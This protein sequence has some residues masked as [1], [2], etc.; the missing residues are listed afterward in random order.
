MGQPRIFY[1]MAKDGLLFPIFGYVNPE[2]HVPTAGILITGVV[3]ATLACL[4]DLEALA[5]VISLGTLLVFTFVDAAVIILRLRP[6]LQPCSLSDRAFVF[7]TP[8]VSRL[9][10]ATP[11]QLTR[12]IRPL[13]PTSARENGS[14]P[15][16]LLI[17]FAISTLLLA[18]SVRDEWHV[19]LRCGFGIT[20]VI[21]SSI[22][23]ALPH[24]DPP[25][26]FNCPCVPLVPLLG[27]AANVFM[28]GSLPNSSW[29]LAMLWLLV[30]LT[31]YLVYGMR[32]STLGKEALDEE[33]Q[34][35]VVPSSAHYN[36][37]PSGATLWQPESFYAD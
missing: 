32:N 7:Q 24:S 3:V 36:A 16:I 29:L 19:G 34:P 12:R 5:N 11:R 28:A 4:V 13:W 26:T 23:M 14:K 15:I 18:I 27:M 35:L 37:I 21:I 2:T 9:G 6:R 31:L 17:T 22:L 8:Q 10:P 20:S 1:S 25:D 30:G 33:G